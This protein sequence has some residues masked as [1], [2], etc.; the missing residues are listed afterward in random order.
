MRLKYV[1]SLLRIMKIPGFFPLM[2]DWQALVRLH[3]IYAALEAGLLEALSTPLSRDDCIRQ[4]K[5]SRPELLDALLDVGLASGELAR[6]DGKFSLRGKRSQA[7]TGRAGD[8][9]SAMVQ[10]NITYYHAAYFHAAERLQ[11]APLG[12]DLEKIGDLVAR[13]SKIGE[14]VIKQFLTGLA[15]GKKPMRVLDVGCGSG[16]HLKTIAEVNPEAT[17]IGVDVDP[18]VV[19]QGRSNMKAWV[20]GERFQIVAGDIRLAPGEAGGPFDLVTLLNILYYFPPPERLGL[21]RQLRSL[22]SEQGRLALAMNF[23]GRGKDLAS[24]HLNLVNC[25]LKGL[26]PLPDLDE[27]A[28]LLKDAGFSRV[29]IQNLIPGSSYYGMAA[30]P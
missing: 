26:E 15:T 30:E 6:R 29:E 11:G 24:A 23:H 20:L 13:F 28:L 8:M 9:L 2:K 3:F 19:E 7:M 12:D 4:L 27:T 25:S 22:L 18:Q 10:A 16:I 1:L 21:L 14:P 17:G 5:I